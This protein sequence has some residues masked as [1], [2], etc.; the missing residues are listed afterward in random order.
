MLGFGSYGKVYEVEDNETKGLFAI[1]DII[2]DDENEK[3][4]VIQEVKQLMK[5][6]SQYVVNCLDAWFEFNNLFIQMELCSQSLKHIIEVKAKTFQRQSNE[7]MDCIEYY[8]T[9]HLM[10]E[11][12]ECIEY[13]HTR[14]PPVIHRD[15]KPANILINDKPIANRFIKLGDFGLSTDHIRTDTHSISHT[16]N[17]GTLKYRAPEINTDPNNCTQKYNEKCDVYSL[18]MILMDIFD[19]TDTTIDGASINIYNTSSFGYYMENMFNLIQQM[20]QIQY[21]ARPTVSFDSKSQIELNNL[22]TRDNTF[23][24]IGPQSSNVLIYDQSDIDCINN[25]VVKANIVPNV[26]LR[27]HKPLQEYCANSGGHSSDLR[28]I[29]AW[30]VKR[31]SY[32]QNSHKTSK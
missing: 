30:K 10:L 21:T 13:L 1:K 22:K 17:V 14:D 9:S 6:R 15:L 32:P 25:C 19:L 16:P 20:K 3:S 28:E 7:P 8:I 11:M 18:G 29:T 4:I 27:Q 2:L 23:Y 31:V 26:Q 24:I 12:C 5:L